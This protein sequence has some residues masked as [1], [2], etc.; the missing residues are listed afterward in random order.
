MSTSSALSFFFDFSIFRF[1]ILIF[2]GSFLSLMA[3]PVF[4]ELADI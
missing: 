3:L 1:F 2:V 4:G